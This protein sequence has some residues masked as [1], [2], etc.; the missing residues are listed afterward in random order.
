MEK[1][2]RETGRAVTVEEEASGGAEAAKRQLEREGP[3]ELKQ[4]VMKRRK[5]QMNKSA[6]Q[7]WKND[8]TNSCTV[9]KSRWYSIVG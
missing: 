7:I 6:E 9:R 1:Y 3:A 2:L 4:R 5:S 8:M